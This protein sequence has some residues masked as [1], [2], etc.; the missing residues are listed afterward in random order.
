MLVGRFSGVSLGVDDIAQAYEALQARGVNFLDPPEEQ[1]WG[2][3]TAH[4][5]DTDENILTIVQ[6]P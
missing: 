6:N 1:P 3:T 5:E 4:F 2:G